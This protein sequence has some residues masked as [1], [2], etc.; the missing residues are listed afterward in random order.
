MKTITAAA[1]GIAI[2]YQDTGKSSFI[3]Y[4]QQNL[5]EKQKV[6]VNSFIQMNEIQR[7]MYR[8][9]LYG[10]KAYTA[11]QLESMSQTTIIQI[12]KDHYRATEV[13]NKLKYDRMYGAYN[14]LLSVIFPQ[15]EL[16][17]YK[18]GKHTPMPSLKELKI[19]T[20]DIVNAWI[21]NKLLPLNF[22]SLNT[23]TVQL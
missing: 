14:K 12:E 1:K 20:N 19:R 7:S 5:A 13:I 21:E 11:D 4:S 9:L 15:V 6:N 22:L 2:N 23:E 16:C 18:D 10:T 17:Y 3:P 8:R